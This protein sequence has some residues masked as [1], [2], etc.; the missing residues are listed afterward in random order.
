MPFYKLSVFQYLYIITEHVLSS[1]QRVQ[2]YIL[3]LKIFPLPLH[4]DEEIA[5]MTMYTANPTTNRLFHVQLQEP[6]Y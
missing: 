5:K 6:G 1:T 2:M 4:V 3:I